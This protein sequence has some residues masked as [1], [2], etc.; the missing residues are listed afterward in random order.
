MEDIRIAIFGCGFW[1]RYQLAA[2][3]E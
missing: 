2:W 3:R 1:A